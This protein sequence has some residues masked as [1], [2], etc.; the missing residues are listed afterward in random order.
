MSVIVGNTDFMNMCLI[1]NCYRDSPFES[2]DLV[3]LDFFFF[4]VMLDEE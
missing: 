2:S 4:F 3:P 1:L